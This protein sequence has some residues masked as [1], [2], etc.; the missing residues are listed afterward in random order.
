MIDSIKIVLRD[1]SGDL[2][3]C[4]FVEP[5]KLIKDIEEKKYDYDNYR[6]YNNSSSAKHYLR[7]SKNKNTGVVTLTGSLRKRAYNR[8]TMLDMPQKDFVQ[9]L[10]GI[11]KDLC[12]PFEELKRA[13][14]TQCE[15]GANIRTRIP[16]I[17]ILPL[18]VDYAHYE[19]INDYIEKGTL[20]FNGADRLLKL[21]VKD[22]EIAAHSFSDEKRE[23]KKMSFDRLKAKGIH[24]LRIEF[25]MKTHRSFR[26]K[27][28]DHVRTIED[29]IDHYSEL[30]DLWTKE[31]SRIIVYNQLKYNESELTKKEKEIIWGLEEVGFF[32]FVDT[33]Q[34]YYML[35]TTT[36]KSMKSAKSKAFDSICSVLDK[37]FDRKE[38][39]KYSLKVDV[40]KYLIGKSKQFQLNLPLLVRNLWGISTINK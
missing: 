32:E 26:N 8:V 18:I 36:T 2:R 4:I 33:Y 11:A 20:Y 7:V 5:K 16:A 31:I 9:T 39:N 23:L 19:R 34:E 37:Y 28:M 22:D 21:Y 1:F 10:K 40:A 12:I 17:D 35:R 27:G 38:Y 25:T 3:N 30:Y 14:F 6:L 13:K 29:L 24:H 15:I